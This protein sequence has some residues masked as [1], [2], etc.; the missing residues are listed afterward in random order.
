MTTH[1]MWYLVLAPG[2]PLYPRQ[3]TLGL[4]NLLPFVEVT[5]VLLPD[6]W[7]RNS[8]GLSLSR[9]VSPIGSEWA[10]SCQRYSLDSSQIGHTL[11]LVFQYVLNC[12]YLR[13]FCHSCAYSSG[14]FHGMNA[15][16]YLW[17]TFRFS[18]RC[19]I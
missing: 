5:R 10:C 4:V 3:G 11:W 2:S 7:Q 13:Q 8:I 6:S 9:S 14:V 18:L 19:I 1:L 12:T 16:V 15:V 17:R